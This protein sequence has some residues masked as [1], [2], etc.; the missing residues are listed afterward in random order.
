MPPPSVE[1]SSTAI[2]SNI[3][4]A[5]SCAAKDSNS[6]LRYGIE[7]NTGTMTATRAVCALGLG[8]E[9]DSRIRSW[10][11][12]TLILEVNLASL[13]CRDLRA[14]VMAILALSPMLIDV[15]VKRLRAA[16]GYSAACFA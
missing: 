9:S 14:V 16:G 7:L 11:S 6:S 13:R 8:P 12:L 4:G 10:P 5:K 2:T 3:S 15:P 1:P